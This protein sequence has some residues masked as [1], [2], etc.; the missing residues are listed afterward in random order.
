MCMRDLIIVLVFFVS[1]CGANTRHQLTSALNNSDEQSLE[2]D[3]EKT[4]AT[5]EEKYYTLIVEA[6]DSND[7]KEVASLWRVATKFGE[8]ERA[9]SILH[10]KI[11]IESVSRFNKFVH[12]LRHHVQGREGE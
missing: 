5:R 1:A 9:A 8:D 11:G 12:M 7:D 10:K 3:C 4:L 2:E 6:I